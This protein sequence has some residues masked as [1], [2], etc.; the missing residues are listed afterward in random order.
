MIIN[1]AK[2]SNPCCH[3]LLQLALFTLYAVSGVWY[4]VSVL[5]VVV[6]VAGVPGPLLQ[7]RPLPRPRPRPRPHR[8]LAPPPSPGVGAQLDEAAADAPVL[9]TE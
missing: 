9:D 6:L 8:S 2:W 3:I 4:L 7:L 5:L 1:T